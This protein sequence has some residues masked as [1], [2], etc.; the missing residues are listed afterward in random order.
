MDGSQS[1]LGISRKPRKQE[2][3][4]KFKQFFIKE[5]ESEN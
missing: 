1:G 2:Y 3:V 5:I 4:A